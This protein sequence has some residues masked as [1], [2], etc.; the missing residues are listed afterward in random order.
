MATPTVLLLHGEESFLVEEEAAAFM[1]ANRSDLV[2]DFGFDQLEPS[3]LTA[4]RLRDAILQAPFLD[5]HRLVA[6]RRIAPARADSLAPA[7]AEIPATTRLLL[8]VNGRL[9]AASKLVKAAAAAGGRAQELSR[10]KGRALNDWASQR[11][12]DLGIPPNLVA[13]V[14]RISPPDLGIVDS[15]LRK[16]ASYQDGGGRLTV[17]VA[18]ELLA[19]GREEEV[20][21]LTDN[22]LP[23]PTAEAMR[24][25]RRLLRSGTGPTLLAYRLAR[26]LATVLEARTRQDR[27]ESLS[28]VQSEMREH[29]FVVQKAFDAARSADP[30][31]LE[32]G[33]RA[34]L[35]FEWEVK[36]GQID[37][38][39]GL[40]AVLAKL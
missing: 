22:L 23:R 33:L 14:T 11:G 19:G 3:G 16:L 36:S 37:A 30:E 32:A 39:L 13:L 31:R 5:P 7:L 20:F 4:A 34:L 6:V 10:M 25:A 38:D 18:Q 9:G 24:I 27:G 8:T 29:P 40:E 2:S 17:A 28:Q 26:H 35:Q 1:S 12:R 15:E 21:K